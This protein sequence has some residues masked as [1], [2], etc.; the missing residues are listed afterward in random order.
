MYTGLMHSHTGLAYLFILSTTAS[1]ILAVMTKFGGPKPGVIKL[2]TILAR[3]V[4]TSCGGL[5]ALVG[6]GMWAVGPLTVGTWW[7]WVALIGVGASGALIARG[8]KPT[9]GALADG[10]ESVSGKWVGMAIGHWA[11]VIA[12]FGLMHAF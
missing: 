12:L 5:V 11:L 2:G 3:F 9:L 6:I 7:L 10:D 1:V 8:I 4:E